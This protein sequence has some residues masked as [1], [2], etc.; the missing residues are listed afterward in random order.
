[1]ID[2]VEDLRTTVSRVAAR[3]LEM[4][5]TGAARHPAPEKW[6]AKEI[7]GHLIDSAANNHLRFVRAQVTNDLVAPGY[8]QE[9]FVRLQ[10]YQQAPWP[11]L[12]TLW[13]EYNLHIARVIEA[14]PDDLR[15]RERREHNLDQIAWQSVPREQPVTLDYFMAD[16][17]A[18]LHHHLRQ[19]E[20]ALG[21]TFGGR[22]A[23]SCG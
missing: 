13:R 21:I 3:L 1:V 14:M 9:D 6:S 17:V 23:S 15:L 18:H 12:V 19:I 20:A 22:A 7:I 2:Y 16:Y 5:D 4:S 11:E 8:P 10:Q